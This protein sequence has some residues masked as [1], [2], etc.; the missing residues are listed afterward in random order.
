MQVDYVW[1]NTAATVVD[2]LHPQRYC[3]NSLPEQLTFN[4]SAEIRF[5][6]NNYTSAN[7]FQVTYELLREGT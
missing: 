6:S 2:P 7:G 4:S 1:Q 5:V 3:G